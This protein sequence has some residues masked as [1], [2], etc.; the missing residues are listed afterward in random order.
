MAK[1]FRRGVSK[2]KFAPT[3]AAYT[4]VT[5]V[6]AG[7]PTR[8]EITAGQDLS[9][10]VSEIAGFQL[11]NSPIPVPDILT[12]YTGQI[13]GEDTVDASSLTLYDDDTTTVVRTALAKGTNG[14][15]LLFPYGD[16]STKRCEVWPV[17]SLGVNDEWTTDNSPARTQV[18]FAVTRVPNQAGVTPA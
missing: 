15:I 7:S 6:G 4:D 17:R 5:G 18:G 9:G 13:N 8:A 14:F 2:V 10:V 3:V 12:T 11:Q 1:F 16:T